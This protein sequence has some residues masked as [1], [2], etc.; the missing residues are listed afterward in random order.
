MIESKKDSLGDRRTYIYSSSI[1]SSLF[2][3]K[4]VLIII[5]RQ[6]ESMSLVTFEFLANFLPNSTMFD[7]LSRMQGG[8]DMKVQLLSQKSQMFLCLHSMFRY[9]HP[10]N[11]F[12]VLRLLTRDTA[13]N[14]HNQVTIFFVFFLINEEKTFINFSNRNI[15]CIIVFFFWNGL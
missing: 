4:I 10:V 9:L 6:P 5:H 7:V 2:K 14:L 13:F 12:S 3:K 1:L 8:V 11:S 15:L